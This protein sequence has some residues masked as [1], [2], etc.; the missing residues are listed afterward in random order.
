LSEEIPLIR[1]FIR[2]GR[3]VLAK[4]RSELEEQDAQELKGQLGLEI[5]HTDEPWESEVFE[6]DC[7]RPA[8]GAEHAMW[9]LLMK[10][11]KAEREACKDDH[12]LSLVPTEDKQV[13]LAAL[14]A[15]YHDVHAPLDNLPVGA[16]ERG[17]A[18]ADLLNESMSTSQLPLPGEA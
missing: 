9:R 11:T 5:L 2:F 4:I 14:W 8:T 15:A 12:W 7:N 10:K 17:E 1:E 16:H 3:T 18:L 13:L 6:Y